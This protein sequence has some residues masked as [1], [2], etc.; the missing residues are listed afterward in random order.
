MTKIR[1]TFLRL[2]AFLQ[3][4]AM[5]TVLSLLLYIGGGLLVGPS[6]YTKVVVESTQE[7]TINGEAGWI[8]KANF[9]K[10][11]CEFVR[12]EVIGITLGVPTII[13]WDPIDG[14]SRNYDRNVGQQVLEIF[15]RPYKGAYDTL[16]IRTRHN[17]AGESV[18]KVFATI[19]LR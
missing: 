12:L 11:A 1:D 7:A 14:D 15:V 5:S 8:V 9:K 3:V 4:M 10:T 13:K 6:P 17:C 18:D 19:S 2:S 16:E